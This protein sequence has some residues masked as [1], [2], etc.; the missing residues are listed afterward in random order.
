MT[1]RQCWV[2]ALASGSGNAMYIG[3]T[4][5]LEKR[6]WE[7]RNGSGSEFVKKYR[8]TRLVYAEEYDNPT[9]AIAREKQLKGWRRE[10]KN[11]LVRSMNPE[12]RDLMPPS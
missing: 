7:H 5:D 10:R 4:N 8:V 12:W 1:D 9:D 3:V 11:E 2:Y 6:V